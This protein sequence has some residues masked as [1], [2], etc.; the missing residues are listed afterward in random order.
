MSAYTLGQGYVN[1]FNMFGR[2]YHVDIESLAKYRRTVNN[3]QDIFVKSNN[4][5]FIP[6]SEL[7]KIKRVVG[8]D[9]IQRFNM[10]DAAQISGAPAPGYSGT[11]YQEHKLAGQHDYTLLYAIILVFLI[12]AALYESWSIP[13]AVIISIPFAIFGA[14][15]SVYLRG[16]NADIYFQVGLVTLVGLSAKNAILIVEFAMYRLKNGMSLF[17]AIIEASKLRFRPI[18]MTS[19]AFIAGTLPLV[20]SSG[21]GANSRHILGTTVVG[22]MLGATLMGIIFIPMFFYLVVRIR[23]IFVK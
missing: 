7:V 9:V 22:G 8:A 23:Q 1:D 17:D 12:L 21:A 6:V 13:I 10:F 14:A 3:L 16:L 4:G 20:F 18:V 5:N 15:L 11:S 2:T 19:M